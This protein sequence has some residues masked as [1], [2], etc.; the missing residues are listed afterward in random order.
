VLS[1]SQR[2]DIRFV[3]Q[4]QQPPRNTVV[5]H[6]A[7]DVAEIH[8]AAAILLNRPVLRVRAVFLRAVV[9]DEGKT[10]FGAGLRLCPQWQEEQGEA[11]E[12]FSHSVRLS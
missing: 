5:F 10:G 12:I 6:H 9:A 11:N 1:P 4:L 8:D 3:G 2:A 7:D